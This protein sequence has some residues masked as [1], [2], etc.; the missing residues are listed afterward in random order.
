[1]AYALL[2]RL[3][4]G[5]I[6]IRIIAQFFVEILVVWL[7]VSTNK[8]YFWERYVKTVV[9]F[10][11]ISL[12]LWFLSVLQINIWDQITPEVDSLMS[13]R[14][15]SDSSTYQEFSYKL[16]GM[17]LYSHRTVDM[18]NVSIFT[19]PGIYQMVL[20]TAIF[21][22]LFLRDKLVSFS[23]KKVGR[24]L[25]ILSCALLSTQSTTGYI[26]LCFIV[27]F[28]MFFEKKENT[29]RNWKQK[30]CIALFVMLLFLMIDYMVRGKE[31]FI[32]ISL[33]SKLFSGEK[34]LSLDE[35][36]MAR[37]D[38]IFLA[39]QSMVRHPFGM[40]YSRFG[41]LMNVQST[42]M[43]GAAIMQFGAAWGILPLIA[44]IWWIF[45]PALKFCKK[46][47]VAVVYIIMYINTVLAQSDLFYPT[48]IM[49][50]IGLYSFDTAY[51]AINNDREE[52]EKL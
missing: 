6:G 51:F 23:D 32:Q 47:Y 33:I 43:A 2:L 5:G 21:V 28:Y 14:I 7:A 26:S 42:G 37:A 3:G 41:T 20:N 4:V 10:A 48:L 34:K 25:M 30:I 1:M 17:F 46:R 11:S 49:I 13:Y 44:V 40:G 12:I 27:L 19:E 15:Y 38:V 8:Q 16:H 39:I 29:E 18:R 24:A 36:G 52:Y 9:F 35:S 50:P 22:L 45:Y 31:S